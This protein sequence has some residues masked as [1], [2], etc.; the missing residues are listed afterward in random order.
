[1]HDLLV[2]HLL[3][4]DQPVGLQLPECLQAIHDAP[5]GLDALS[6]EAEEG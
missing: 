3:W 5:R 2:E 6:G 4:A 1:M